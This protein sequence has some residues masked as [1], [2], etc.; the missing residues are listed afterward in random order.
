M[1]LEREQMRYRTDELYH[2]GRK[3]MKWGQHIF[4][5]VKTNMN[6]RRL[7][8]TMYKEYNSSDDVSYSTKKSILHT[9]SDADKKELRTLR[10]SAVAESDKR[11][12]ARKK[13]EGLY[14]KY[15]NEYLKK[16]GINAPKKHEDRRKLDD[17]TQLALLEATDY[18]RNKMHANH[19]KLY[20][21]LREDTAI[22][23]Y[24]TK[25]IQVTEKLLGKYGNKKL[26]G[27]TKYTDN[28]AAL[29]VND[30]I[31]DLNMRNWQLF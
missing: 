14:H 23:A 15:E 12:A 30:M 4:G 20:K 17:E 25:C 28:N 31:D 9:I 24:S 7:Y 11:V 22:S 6:Q 1:I 3:G 8:K 18:A 27:M 29:F 19:A 10:N 13:I 2:S 5:K 26:R 21:Q 16:N